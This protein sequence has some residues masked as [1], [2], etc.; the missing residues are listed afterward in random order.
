MSKVDIVTHPCEYCGKSFTRKFSLQRH[1]TVC[2]VKRERNIN[3]KIKNIRRKHRKK[4]QELTDEN[5]R[6]REKMKK[7][8]LEMKEKDEEIAELK[9]KCETGKI[10]VY[11]KV[12]TKALDNQP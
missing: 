9:V 6:L 4:N 3:E 2:S 8:K 5:F 11:D 10:E 7:M 1:L 12:C